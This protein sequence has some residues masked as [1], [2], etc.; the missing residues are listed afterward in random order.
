MKLKKVRVTNYKSIDDSEDFSVRQLTCLAGKNEAGKSALLQALRRLNPVE[1]TEHDFDDLMEY[2]RRRRSDLRKGGEAA[3]VLNTEWELEEEELSAIARVFGQG[4]LESTVCL[5]RGYDNSTTWTLRLN[6][7]S[8]VNH[9]LS[10]GKELTASA[11]QR[12]GNCPT[13]AQLRAALESEESRSEGEQSV[14]DHLNDVCPAEIDLAIRNLLEER[15]PRF[16]YFPRYATLQGKVSLQRLREI[17][18]APD[19][20]SDQDR[21]FIALLRLAGAS[22]EQIADSSRYEEQ[23]AQLESVSNN[24]SDEIFKYWSQNRNLEVEFDFHPGLAEDPPPFDR[25]HV[26]DLRIRNKR[27]RVT[28]PFD[29]RSTGFV[30]FFSFLVYF[31]QMSEMY[32]DNLLVLLDEPGLTLHGKAQADLLR[33][34]KER[35]LPRCQV[36]YTTHSPFMID[37]S[38]IIGVRTVEDLTAESGAVIGTKVSEN[39][40]SADSDTLLPLRVALGYDLTQSLF[41]GENSLLV[42]GSSDLLFLQWASRRSKAAG[43][44]GLDSRW[45]ITPVGGITKVAGFAS[46][47]GSNLLNLAVLVDLHHGDKKKVRDLEENEM[48]SGNRVF[49]CATFVDQQEADTEDMLGRELYAEIVNGAYD[50]KKKKR[51]KPEEG[52]TGPVVKAVEKHFRTVAIEGPE[53]DHL[54][55]AVYLAEHESDFSDETSV[56]DAVSRFEKF[57]TKVNALLP[58]AEE[59]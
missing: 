20:Q 49:H 56:V 50:L 53:F 10:D 27:H 28:V 19:Q 57:F 44:E 30:W 3:N 38:D 36:I 4:A 37:P 39:S 35:L 7:E 6:E 11:S 34:V 54:T 25:G 17:Q 45:T 31:S 21:V 42:E 15:L 12:L 47:F 41:I 1:E 59:T 23:K 22:V 13:V 24:V 16:L 43:R 5:Q 8:I 51:F 14:L 33:Y 2:P 55:P 40:V 26:I 32:G 9:L 46:L 29:E 18:N 48:L 58:E 52:D